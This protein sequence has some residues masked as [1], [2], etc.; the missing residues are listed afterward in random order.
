MNFKELSQHLVTDTCPLGSGFEVTVDAN[1]FA[2]ECFRRM[3][4]TYRARAEEFETNA[5]LA[6]GAVQTVG[7]AADRYEHTQELKAI[8][9]DVE[10]EV[11]ADVLASDR[12]GI[13]TGWKL[14][15]GTPPTFE[16]L[17]QLDAAKLRF[18]FEWARET[19]S[20]KEHGTPIQTPLNLTTSETTS[21]GSSDLTTPSATSQSM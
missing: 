4:R 12:Y 19:G 1:K 6:D 7:E 17:M 11:L 14:D 18:L 13:I 2:G 9:F 3:A 8:T 20:P 16:N 5:P 10:R 21:D 15:D